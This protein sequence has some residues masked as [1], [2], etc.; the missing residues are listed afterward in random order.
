[1]CDIGEETKF[2]SKVVYKVVYTIDGKHYSIFSGLKI[3]LGAVRNMNKR[4][5]IGYMTF[6]TYGKYDH[7]YNE[8]MIGR[9]TGFEKL[10]SAQE[11]ARVQSSRR[12]IKIKLGGKLLKGTAKRLLCNGYKHKVY[13]GTRIL[14]ITEIK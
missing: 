14:S 1:M 6:N 2:K 9:T 13:A 8:N 3:K 12:V 10:S 7:F 4:K 11:L 5:T